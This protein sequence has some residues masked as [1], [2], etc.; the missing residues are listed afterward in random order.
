MISHAQPARKQ[1]P[2]SGVTGPGIFLF[3][4]KFVPNGADKS[5]LAR[6]RHTARRPL[7]FLRVGRGLSSRRD[8]RGAYVAQVDRLLRRA[9]AKQM[10]LRSGS[11]LTSTK[12]L[13]DPR[14]PFCA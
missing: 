6:A 2:P 8:R 9:M 7:F 4:G 3:S 5:A 13:L 11:I 14:R 1:R 10:R 12:R